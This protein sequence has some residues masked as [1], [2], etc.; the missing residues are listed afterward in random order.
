MAAPWAPRLRL[1]AL[2]GALRPGTQVVLDLKGRN[3]RLPALVTAALGEHAPEL[4][5]LVCARHW[6]LL[7]LVVSSP[8]VR[9]VY[10][11]GTRRQLAALLRRADMSGRGVSIHRELLDAPTV[12]ELRRR[13][14]LVMTWPVATPEQVRELVGW[15]VQGM[16]TEHPVL[17]AGELRG[18]RAAA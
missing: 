5:V 10:S 3:R 6:P 2:L 17:V 13:A 12:A 1:E 11:V 8:S 7:D 15:G 16:I 9:L 14:D 18:L 4:P